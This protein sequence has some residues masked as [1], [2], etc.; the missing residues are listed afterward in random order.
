VNGE[1]SDRAKRVNSAP[2]TATLRCPA[3]RW[4]RSTGT[5]SPQIPDSP[6][7]LSGPAI[8][9][10]QAPVVGQFDCGGRAGLENWRTAAH[11]GGMAQRSRPLLEVAI[12]ERS[13]SSWEWSVHFG[14]EVLIFGVESTHA[15][16]R[17][18]GNDALFQIL[19]SAP[20]WDE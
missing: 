7:T 12:V 2:A 3:L 5:C 6:A 11:I 1:P 19:T 20:G 15:G 8:G 4:R 18:A 10:S 16:A 14:A 17:F 13:T 9:L